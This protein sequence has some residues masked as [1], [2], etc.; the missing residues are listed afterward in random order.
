VILLD[1]NVIS[2]LMRA[3]PASQ[4]IAW[5][6]E[7]VAETLHLSTVSLAELLLGSALLPDGRRKADLSTSLETR[8]AALFGSR[9][10]TF[11]QA[12]AGAFAGIVSR[13]RASGFSIGTADAQ[14]AATAASR[15]FSV[16]T[17]DKGP[18]EAAGLLVINPWQFPA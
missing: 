1:T 15:G 4:V 13:T 18:F 5:L 14:I 3:A 9:I 17:R 12:A 10:L 16:A 11:D 7:Q 2:E 6:D 8:A